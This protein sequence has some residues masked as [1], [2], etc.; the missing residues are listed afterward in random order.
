MFNR[1]LIESGQFLLEVNGIELDRDRF[2]ILVKTVLGTYNKYDPIDAKFNLDLR[3]S[4]KH[5]FTDDSE[6][7]GIPDWISSVTPIQI[8]TT[9]A[10]HPPRIKSVGSLIAYFGNYRSNPEL[11]EKC[12]FSIDYRKPHLYLPI[13]EIVDVH[14]VYS[15]KL[16]EEES[17]GNILYHIDTI[18]HSFD[19]FFDLL[20]AKF[21]IAIGRSRRAFT[22]QDLPIS[23]DADQLVS[24]GKE[25]ENE[26]M[27]EL[28]ENEG[29]QY[30]SW[31]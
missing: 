23:S 8:N 18:D 6:P 10:S 9:S 13:E 25:L 27:E 31:G 28:I 2:V 19:T 1:I 21:M 12:T 22:L 14:A 3:F 26:T 16:R 24:E 15:H 30:L 4:R 20:R 5:T 17:F 29:K 11:E 7:Y